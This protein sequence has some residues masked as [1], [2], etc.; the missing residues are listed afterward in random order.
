[1]IY[2]YSPN[3]YRNQC[4]HF[5]EDSIFYSS[6]YTLYELALSDRVVHRELCLRQ[7]AL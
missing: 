4:L 3:W 5:R 2:T 1:M 7:V 6:N